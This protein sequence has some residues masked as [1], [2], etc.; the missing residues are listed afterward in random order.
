M[1]VSAVVHGEWR[2]WLGL[3][4]LV[5]GEVVVGQGCFAKAPDGG[6]VATPTETTISARTRD[7][8]GCGF[9]FGRGGH[10]LLGAG[11]GLVGI[12]QRDPD[13]IVLVLG[14]LSRAGSEGKENG[15]L[16]KLHGVG[17]HGGGVEEMAGLDNILRERGGFI[18]WIA[19]YVAD[20]TADEVAGVGVFLV[21]VVG[22]DCALFRGNA[23]N[24]QVAAAVELLDDTAVIVGDELGFGD[25]FLS[26]L[27]LSCHG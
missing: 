27:G 4:K 5:G 25:D 26:G 14:L 13:D 17:N 21:V 8:R 1:T 16:K 23:E 19:L 10:L 9:G 20:F 3:A 22:A 2:G 24:G 15:V 11:S 12:D 6:E 7:P 18:G